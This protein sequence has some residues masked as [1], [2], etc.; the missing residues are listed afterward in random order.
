ML[1]LL[2][3]RLA[4][5]LGFDGTLDIFNK[6]VDPSFPLLEF[7]DQSLSEAYTWYRGSQCVHE[8]VGILNRSECERP[9][10]RQERPDQRDPADGEGHRVLE[11]GDEPRVFPVALSPLDGE[12]LVLACNLR[13]VCHAA[14]IQRLLDANE[15][16]QT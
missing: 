4:S 8:V 15:R 1:N 10:Y 6:T 16:D 14:I 5:L 9:S 7:C 13:P 12:T 3:L 11:K 2:I